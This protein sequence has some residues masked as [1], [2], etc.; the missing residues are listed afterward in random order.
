MSRRSASNSRRFQVGA[1]AVALTLSA[2]SAAMAAGV[3]RASAYFLSTGPTV[4]LYGDRI[5]RDVRYDFTLVNGNARSVL[6]RTIGQN[7]PGLELLVPR[8]SATGRLVPPAG[9]GPTYAVR[10]HASIRLTVLFHVSDCA[11]VPKGSWPLTMDVA[12]SPGKWQRVAL[13]LAPRGS[14][15]WPRSLVAFVC[16]GN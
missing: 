5:H 14:V 10:A 6:V 8:G 4:H 11:A 1:L 2:G 7:G 12:W 9:P 16:P 15:P 3:R 13:P